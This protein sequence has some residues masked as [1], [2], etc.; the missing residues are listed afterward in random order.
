MK[1]NIFYSILFLFF[2]FIFS[3]FY[4]GL[5][6]PNFYTPKEIKNE[7]LEAFSSKELFSNEQF[8]SNNLIENN[9]FTLI[10]IWS[11]WCVPCR[12]EHS[13]LMD[14]SEKTDL[15]IVGLNYKDKKIMLLNF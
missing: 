5:D 2:L 3:I 14:L 1:K 6:K 8:S 13:V 7:N 15:N 9:K 12:L 10:N 11:S 4:I